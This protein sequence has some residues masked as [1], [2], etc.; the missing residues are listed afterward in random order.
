MKNNKPIYYI[1]GVLRA[2]NIFFDP[3]KALSKLQNIELTEQ[4]ERYVQ[5]RTSYYCR[6]NE[7]F[8]I[9]DKAIQIKELRWPI[10][11]STYKIDSYE[12]LRYF[13]SELAVNIEFGDVNYF[14]PTPT[15]VK[16]RPI[17]ESF[18][19][20][21][22]S[23]N[24]VLLKLN[25][26]RH[27]NFVSDEIPYDKKESSIF[28]RGGIYQPHRV[29]FFNKFYNDPMCDLGHVGH[30]NLHPQWEKVEASIADHLRY[31]FIMALEGNDV[32][33]NLKW[34][35][36]SNSIAVMPKPKFETWFMEGKLVGG[37]H[38]IEIK[39][40]Y[41]DLHEKI[42]YYLR[43]PKEAQRI[44]E[45]SHAYVQQFKRDD[46]EA[47]ISTAILSKYIGLSN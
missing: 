6:I 2:F 27:F 41:S 25:K 16:S 46:I 13:D 4:E 26:I 3:K 7:S 28:Y 18:E 22:D 37:Y 42:D 5:E 38:Y 8:S 44:I 12:F 20:E 24:S 1:K 39:D 47:L 31:K 21:F 15:L 34:I 10:K 11:K 45:N 30:K 35:M 17:R 23:R 29:D 33:S 40:D 43:H 14:L 36:S 9:E 19:N 32:A